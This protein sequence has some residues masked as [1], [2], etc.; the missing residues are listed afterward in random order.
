MSQPSLAKLHHEILEEM[1]APPCQ[2][3]IDYFLSIVDIPENEVEEYY[4]FIGQPVIKSGPESGP[5]S[6]PASLPYDLIHRIAHEDNPSVLKFRQAYR[7]EFKKDPSEKIIRRFLQEAQS[8]GAG[9]SV[10]DDK[11]LYLNFAQAFADS[12]QPTV[13]KFRNSFKEQFKIPPPDE[14][15]EYFLKIISE[16]P[17]SNADKEDYEA[18]INF[19]K[20]VANGLISTVLQFRQAYE[21]V[22]GEKPPTEI[23]NV[24]IENLPRQ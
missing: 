18:K 22:Y 16:A 6:G 3:L 15:T 5:K 4:K 19:A 1:G 24:F 11:R 8:G 13:L 9:K 2:E 17:K 21:K 20:T 12:P 14:V 23:I 10:R 7:S